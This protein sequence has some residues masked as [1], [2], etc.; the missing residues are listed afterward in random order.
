MPPWRVTLP[1]SGFLGASKAR[2]WYLL[3]V[4]EGSGSVPRTSRG[5]KT[6]LDFK[7]LMQKKKKKVS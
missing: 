1:T 7:Y 2:L 6:F 3:V 4:S 5:I